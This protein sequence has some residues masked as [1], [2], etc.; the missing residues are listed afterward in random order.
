MKKIK[1]Q[2]RGWFAIVAS[3]VLIGGGVAVAVN[4]PRLISFRNRLVDS[5]IVRAEQA[6][7]DSRQEQMF[8]FLALAQSV[9]FGDGKASSQTSSEY[10]SIGRYDLAEKTIILSG[11]SPNYTYLG[12]IA[13]RAQHYL[14]AASYFS[15]AVREQKNASSL[16][17]L[18]RAMI[19]IGQVKDGCAKNN[20]AIKNDLSDKTAETV[21][22]ICQSLQSDKKSGREL[23]YKEAD[24]YIYG[25]AEK[26]L[27]AEQNK[28]ARDWLLLA[29]I[30][31]GRGDSGRAVE[32]IGHAIELDDVDPALTKF[33]LEIYKM[34]LDHLDKRSA[35]ANNLQTR[36]Q[37]LNTKFQHLPAY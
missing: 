36:T 7:R 30:A 5:F 12:N 22:Q 14:A 31:A 1:K 27:L 18:G 9:S 35:E 11:L 10:L 8:S 32:R 23:A 3:L 25:Q 6:K 2:T 28:T 17:G 37:Q 24:V 29:Q 13:L 33:A 19:G 15:I 4:L 21:A 34:R 26:T 20:E 16:S